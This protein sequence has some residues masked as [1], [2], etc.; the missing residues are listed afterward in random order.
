MVTSA[1]SLTRSGLSD[2]IIQRVSAVIL[3]L[4]TI[5]I[6]GFLL[7]TPDL[8]YTTWVDFHGGTAMRLFSTLAVLAVAAHAWI[9][10]W[11]VG[12]DYIRGHYFG[13][14]ATVFRSIY[15]AVCV[16]A[17]FIFVAW[18]LQLFWRL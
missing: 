3:A 9:G 16:G 2:F 15:M 4:Y 12:T 5:C 18:S 6:T 11:T 14:R 8:D 7:V 1:T 10:M 13:Q 17:L